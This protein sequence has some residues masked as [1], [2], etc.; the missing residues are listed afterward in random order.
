M[1]SYRAEGYDS[2]YPLL[3]ESI[4]GICVSRL[5]ATQSAGQLDNASDVGG[6][7]GVEQPGVACT[8]VEGIQSKYVT[9]DCVL[10]D[11]VT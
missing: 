3:R 4:S 11:K 1:Q 10:E 7:V 8:G 5:T 6:G 2:L 9:N